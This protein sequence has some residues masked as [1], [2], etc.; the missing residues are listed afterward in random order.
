MALSERLSRELKRHVIMFWIERSEYYGYGKVRPR[1][2]GKA[3]E[4]R[5]IETR[6]KHYLT[7]PD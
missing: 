2:N 7:T 4:E 3:V 5:A 1:S 6:S